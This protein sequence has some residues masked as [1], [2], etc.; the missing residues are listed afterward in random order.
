MRIGRTRTSAA[1]PES[2]ASWLRCIRNVRRPPNHQYSF[3]ETVSAKHVE[4]VVRLGGGLL[5]FTGMLIMTYN[6][7]RTVRM[8]AAAE[9]AVT[10]AMLPVAAPAAAE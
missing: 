1:Y 7:W 2:P 4:N 6:L 5:F 10:P 3:I 8:P 9:R